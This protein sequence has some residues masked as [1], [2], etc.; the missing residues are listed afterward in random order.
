MFIKIKVFILVF[1]TYGHVG[2]GCEKIS[3][4]YAFLLISQEM[5]HFWFANRR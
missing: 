3:H 5:F 2:A 1:A 4:S